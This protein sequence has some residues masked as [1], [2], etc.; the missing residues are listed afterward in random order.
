MVKFAKN[1]L[2]QLRN[3]DRVT[4]ERAFY[5]FM[6]EVMLFLRFYFYILLRLMNILKSSLDA[7]VFRS[8]IKVPIDHTIVAVPLLQPFI[9]LGKMATVEL[10]R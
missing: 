3:M 9:C 8:N 6:F 1:K 4:P 2:S 10:K 5:Y 7:S